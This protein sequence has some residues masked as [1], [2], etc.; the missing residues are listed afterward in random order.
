MEPKFEKINQGVSGALTSDNCLLLK[1]RLEPSSKPSEKGNH[2]IA[3]A[4]FEKMGAINPALRGVI[5]NLGLYLD[6]A[7]KPTRF[8]KRL[9]GARDV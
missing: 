7:V 3:F 4:K 6:K 8:L 5:L 9:N 1:I 2:S